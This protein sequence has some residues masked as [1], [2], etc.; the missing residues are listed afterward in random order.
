MRLAHSR[1]ATAGGHCRS[2]QGPHQPA[3]AESPPPA[4]T[5]CAPSAPSCAPYGGAHGRRADRGGSADTQRMR[6]G[7]A[8]ETREREAPRGDV[9]KEAAEA[10]LCLSVRLFPLAQPHLLSPACAEASPASPSASTVA[11]AILLPLPPR[12]LWRHGRR[13]LIS[14]AGAPQP[15]MTAEDVEALLSRQPNAP[16]Y[17]CRAVRQRS[18]RVAS[19]RP[20]AQDRTRARE[21][22]RVVEASQAAAFCNRWCEACVRSC[23]RLLPTSALGPGSPLP[24]RGVGLHGAWANA[25]STTGST[26]VTTA[27]ADAAD[28]R[29]AAGA[30]RSEPGEAA[31]RNMPVVRIYVLL[32]SVGAEACDWQRALSQHAPRMQA[33]MQDARQSESA[34]LVPSGRRLRALRHCAVGMEGRS[35]LCAA[36]GRGGDAADA[37]LPAAAPALQRAQG[38]SG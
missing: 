35:P 4:S 16:N 5:A 33:C 28:E 14:P 20:S 1:L 36:A 30:A 27:P 2:E 7:A 31:R 37:R 26:K 19:A 23:A 13:A 24:H 11:V 34:S 9:P 3:G 21:C 38:Q 29:E 32:P 12:T 22:A 15:H 10:A 8:D 6:I 25:G 17:V 18:L